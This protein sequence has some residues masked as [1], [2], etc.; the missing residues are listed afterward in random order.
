MFDDPA[1]VA[2]F[3]WFV[4]SEGSVGQYDG[5]DGPDTSVRSHAHVLCKAPDFQSRAQ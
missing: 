4:S 5:F 3:L 2:E 1:V